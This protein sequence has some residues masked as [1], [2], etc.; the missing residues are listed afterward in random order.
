MEKDTANSKET[1]KKEEVKKSGEKQ[2]RGVKIAVMAAVCVVSVLLCCTIVWLLDTWKH[3]SMD[4]L[5]FQIQA[6]MAGTNKGMILEYMIKCL[7]LT[8]T[9]TRGFAEAIITRG[10]ISV[11]DI[12]PSTMESRKVRGLYFAGEIL[13]LDAVTG[14]FNLQIAW[15]TGW[16]AGKAAAL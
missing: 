15:S 4:E 9:G 12:N 10:G 2:F 5:V 14:G 16:A 11:K 13:D 8:V 7:P 3:L 1:V 6:P